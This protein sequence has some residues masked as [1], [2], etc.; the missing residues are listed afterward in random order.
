MFLCAL[1][2]YQNTIFTSKK[3]ILIQLFQSSLILYSEWCYLF[4]IY[5]TGCTICRIWDKITIWRSLFKNMKN[6]ALTLTSF[7]PFSAVSLDLPRYLIFAV[8]CLSPLDM[9]ILAG[10]VQVLVG[11]WRPCSATQS[12]THCQAPP[13]PTTETIVQALFGVRK[14]SQASALLLGL[15]PEPQTDRQPLGLWPPHQDPHSAWSGGRWGAWP[16][17]S[18]LERAVALPTWDGMTPAMPTVRLLACTPDHSLPDAT[19]S[20]R[21]GWRRNGCARRSE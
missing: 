18:L 19:S 17:E 14:L 13:P 2:L 8:E 11:A 4:P 7:F 12:P 3:S 15:L 6:S 16:A 10:Q 1:L 20:P 9:E 21:T 5:K